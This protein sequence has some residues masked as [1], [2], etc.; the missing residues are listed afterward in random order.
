[1]E[2]CSTA[3]IYIIINESELTIKSRIE[4]M[5]ILFMTTS[6]GIAITWFHCPD[7]NYRASIV[8]VKTLARSSLPG[9]VVKK[10]TFKS[11]G[12]TEKSLHLNQGFLSCD[13]IS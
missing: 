8:T 13:Q 12:A 4:I 11:A 10:R 1:M 3:K 6:L 2:G 9:E 5:K 7:K